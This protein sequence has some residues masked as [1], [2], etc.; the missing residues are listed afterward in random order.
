MNQFKM[1][2]IDPTQIYAQPQHFIR[3]AGHMTGTVFANILLLSKP[4]Y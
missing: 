3:N 1:N 4:P 2:V